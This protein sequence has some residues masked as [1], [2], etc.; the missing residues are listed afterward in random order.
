VAAKAGVDGADGDPPV[1]YPIARPA[2][3]QMDAIQ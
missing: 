3:R 1:R 2:T